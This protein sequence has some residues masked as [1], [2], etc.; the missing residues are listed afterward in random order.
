MKEST[1][2]AREQRK[3]D[4]ML[5]QLLGITLEEVQASREKEERDDKTREVQAIHLFL[6]QPDAFMT[7]VCDQCNGLFMTNY[8]FVSLC[9]TPCRV[10]SLDKMG[11]TWNPMHTATERWS[12][13]QIPAEYSIPPAAL[14]TLLQIAEEQTLLES[15][16]NADHD[17]FPELFESSPNIEQLN[18]DPQESPVE[19]PPVELSFEEED[20]LL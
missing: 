15:V 2:K 14:K 20:Y 7:K 16:N 12:R 10:K 6:E 1:R 13:A 19:Q 17:E 18:N 3:H 11:I 5:A 4:E 9:S 8:K